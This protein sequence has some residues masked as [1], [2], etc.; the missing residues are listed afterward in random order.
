MMNLDVDDLK[1]S[2]VTQAIFEHVISKILTFSMTLSE[3]SRH[4]EL[5]R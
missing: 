3:P 4:R 5:N 2:I 1:G